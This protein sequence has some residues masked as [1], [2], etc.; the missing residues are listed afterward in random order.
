[1]VL[2]LLGAAVGREPM[3]SARQPDPR[4]VFRPPTSGG[5]LASAILE[6]LYALQAPQTPDELQSLMDISFGGS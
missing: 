4:F 1:M 6:A 3:G 5:F 2:P